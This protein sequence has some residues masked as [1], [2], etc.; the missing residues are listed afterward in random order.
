MSCSVPP[1]CGG[2][3]AGRC[4]PLRARGADCRCMQSLCM[5]NAAAALRDNPPTPPVPGRYTALVLALQWGPTKIRSQ[6]GDTAGLAAEYAA[7]LEQ[8]QVNAGWHLHGLW[9][10]C[11]CCGAYSLPL[12]AGLLLAAASHCPAA[13]TAAPTSSLHARHSPTH[14]FPHYLLRPHLAGRH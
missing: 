8:G 2:G 12:T 7:A 10:A 11:M 6:Q 5:H 1:L 3:R 4:C 13:A 14:R 9:C